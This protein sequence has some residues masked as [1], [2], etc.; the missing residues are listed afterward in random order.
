MRRPAFPL[1]ASL[2]VVM[3][4]AV[5]AAGPAAWA[6]TYVDDAVQGLG[7]SAAWVSDEVSERLDLARMTAGDPEGLVTVVVLPEQA[8]LEATVA[9][10]AE[11]V[12]RRAGRR[13]VLAAIG[14]DFSARSAD[15]PAGEAARLANEAEGAGA[16]LQDAL[17]SAVTALA[18]ALA[19]SSAPA[20]TPAPARRGAGFGAG[21]VV[22]TVLGILVVVGLGAGIAR[23]AVRRRGR[24]TLRVSRATPDD[25]AAHLTALRALRGRYLSLPPASHVQGA[26][27]AEVMTRIIADTSE[28]FRRLARRGQRD[29][30]A[31]AEVEYRDQLAKV[32][33]VL[34]EDYYLDILAR[35]DLWEDPAGRVEAVDRAVRAFAEQIVANIRQVN[36]A[37]DLRFQVSLD[38]LARARRDPALDIYDTPEEGQDP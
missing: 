25:V 10:M 24:R 32:A 38:A 37:Q 33:E 4:V 16:S 29:Q 8:S 30:M 9:D 36:A 28:L 13:T 20:S 23:L 21:R 12:A 35:P 18:G 15:L 2:T 27:M 22:G 7:E 26:G 11:E 17:A 19:G 14:R 3:A 34:G 31:V 5:V 1:R 6:D